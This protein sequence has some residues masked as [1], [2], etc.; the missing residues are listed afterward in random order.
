MNISQKMQHSF[1]TAVNNPENIQT[2]GHVSWNFVDADVYMDMQPI[3]GEAHY[4]AF[5]FL[6]NKFEELNGKQIQLSGVLSA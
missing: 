5:E 1:D 2:N 3:D 4:N 6:G